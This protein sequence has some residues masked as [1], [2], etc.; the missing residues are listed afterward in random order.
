MSN[1]NIGERVD[2]NSDEI[3]KAISI[4][5]GSLNILEGTMLTSISN[6]FK[7]L[8]SL[9]LFTDGLDKLKTQIETM[10][11][12]NENL[13][14]KISLHV[15]EM[16]EV[17]ES[18]VAE[19]NSTFIS[20]GNYGGGGGG[21]YYSD[22]SQISVSTV[23][24]NTNINNNQVADAINNIKPIDINNILSFLNINKG[25]YSISDIL[26]CD[27]G[28]G[29]LLCLLKKFYGDK[30]IKID[31]IVSKDSYDIQKTLLEKL[32][33]DDVVIDNKEF[34]SS[35]IVMEKEY[36][37]SIAKEN[38][39]A[40]SELLLNEKYE[41]LLLSSIEKLYLGKDLEKYNLEENAIENVKLYI[42]K[43]ADDNGVSVE[44]VLSDVNFLSDLKGV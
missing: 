3:M 22:I 43:V 9:G 16:Q 14:T 34:N 27:V 12:S 24:E 44:K 18:I 5:D 25:E 38:D 40:V 8:S 11:K 30:D 10:K 33:N 17:E 32:L 4:L 26:F 20:S 21:S 36:F 7:V 1:K 37:K 19:V 35:L 28:S 23:T 2:I 31:T 15:A 6:D 29:I 13:M 39:I 42:E 41:T